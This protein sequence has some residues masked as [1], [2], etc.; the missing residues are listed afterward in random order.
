[1]STNVNIY[2]CFRR[3][4]E[5]SVYFPPMPKHWL[6]PQEI[7]PSES[8]TEA[9]GGHPLVAQTLARRGITD[10]EAAR[11]FLDPALYTPAPPSDFPGLTR[12]ASRIEQAIQRAETILVWGDFDVDGQTSTTLLVESLRNLGANVTYHI[13]IRLTEGH[14]IKPEI[15][16]RQDIAGRQWGHLAGGTL[17][18][19]ELSLEAANEVGNT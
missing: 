12:A 18:G 9:I 4:Y 1:M 15:L 7:F 14:G 16:A 11:A 10:P 13:P 3:A 5:F 19:P 2:P 6:P 17:R 8:L